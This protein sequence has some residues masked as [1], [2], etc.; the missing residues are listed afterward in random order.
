MGIFLQGCR[1]GGEAR[2]GRDQGVYSGLAPRP[3]L[4]PIPS[5]TQFLDLA[6]GSSP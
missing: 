4:A 3:S 5:Q 2:K 1:W 6:L